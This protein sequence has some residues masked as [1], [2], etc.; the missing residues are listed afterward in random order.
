MSI[1]SISAESSLAKGF[2]VLGF[3]PFYNP[4]V[5]VFDRKQ[6]RGTSS[7][8]L[9]NDEPK[10]GV[11]ILIETESTRGMHNVSVGLGGVDPNSK[12]EEGEQQTLLGRVKNH[13]SRPP[14]GVEKWDKAILVCDWEVDIENRAIEIGS[15]KQETQDKRIVDAMKREVRL[16]E[17]MLHAEL[18]KFTGRRGSLNVHRNQEKRFKYFMPNPDNE[19]YEYYIGIAKESLRHIGLNYDEPLMRKEIKYYIE[20]GLLVE[21]EAVYGDYGSKAI[22]RNKKGNADVEMFMKKNKKASKNDLS[23]LQNVSLREAALAI[24]KANEKKGNVSAPKFWSAIKDNEFVK[25]ED[26]E[27]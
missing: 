19:R 6:A 23:V 1:F 14:S 27:G 17:K 25:I 5:L 16:L 15:V 2:T 13:V 18:M 4:N 3:V 11:Y 12:T 26:L 10:K 7:V 8:K 24:Y 9:G 21:G 22:I 20:A